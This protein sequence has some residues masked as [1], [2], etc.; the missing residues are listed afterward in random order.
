MLENPIFVGNEG[1]PMIDL[2]MQFHQFINN[3]YLPYIGSNVGN[4]L[5]P[6]QKLALREVIVAGSFGNAAESLGKSKNTVAG[7]LKRVSSKRYPGAY[8]RLG[9][10][11]LV[12]AALVALARGELN[13]SEIVYDL[14]VDLQNY[15]GLSPFQKKVL[16][17]CIVSRGAR[18]D[19]I[20]ALDLNR[21]EGHIGNSFIPI[22]QQLAV[23]TRAQA[24]VVAFSVSCAQDFVSNPLEI[25][26]TLLR[27]GFT[28]G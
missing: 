1:S 25:P 20:I 17:S 19:K 28:S 2:N 22:Y 16:S 14:G 13:L 11:S 6:G 10:E 3:A 5:T 12:E 27:F 24:S 15:K 9:A 26:E 4:R 23:A 21:S 8:E 7:H 18:S